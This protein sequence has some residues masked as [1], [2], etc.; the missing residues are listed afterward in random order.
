[1]TKFSTF[2]CAADR[3][4]CVRFGMVSMETDVSELLTLV[5]KTGIELDE[6]VAQLN[7]MGEV[8]R[9]GIEQAQGELRHGLHPFLFDN[10][11]HFTYIHPPTNI[12]LFPRRE[13]DDALLQ[14]GLLRHVPIVGSFVNWFSPVTEKATIKGRC[15]S[16]NEGRL[17]TTQPVYETKAMVNGGTPAVAAAETSSEDAPE[18]APA[19]AAAEPGKE[20]DVASAAE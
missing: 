4:I 8:I 17:S 5:V 15:L 12:E 9:R 1:M 11:F 2:S 7:D 20:S 6:Q 10:E 3:R 19:A 18:A 14:E 13:S 16:L